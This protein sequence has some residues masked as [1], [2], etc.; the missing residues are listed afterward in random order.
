LAR[1]PQSDRNEKSEGSPQTIRVRQGISGQGV[2]YVL[3]FSLAAVI[4]AFILV[5]AFTSNFS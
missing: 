5:A 2:I 3:G 4:I 1:S